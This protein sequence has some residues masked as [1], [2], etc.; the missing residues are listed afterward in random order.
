[1]VAIREFYAFRIQDRV[2]ES[3][4]IKQYRLPWYQHY[5][6]CL[7][8]GSYSDTQDAINAVDVNAKPIGEDMF[9]HLVH[10]RAMLYDAALSGCNCNLS[11]AGTS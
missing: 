6:G 4:V 9:Y 1:M 11:C 2:G 3:I 10:W 7:Q 8:T 5:Q